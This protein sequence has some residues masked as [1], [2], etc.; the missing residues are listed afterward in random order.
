MKSYFHDRQLGGI[1][2]TDWEDRFRNG[3]GPVRVLVREGQPLP[4][5]EVLTERP[6]PLDRGSGIATRVRRN[7]AQRAWGKHVVAP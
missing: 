5:P 7:K 2:I 6:A 4:E 1:P 3:D